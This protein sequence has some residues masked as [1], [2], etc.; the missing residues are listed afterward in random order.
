VNRVIKRSEGAKGGLGTKSRE[1]VKERREDAKE[2][3]NHPCFPSSI[4]QNFSQQDL[5]RNSLGRVQLRWPLVILRV[6]PSLL[7]SFAALSSVHRKHHIPTLAL[8]GAVAGGCMVGPN[9]KV[10]KVDVPDSFATTQPTAASLS[11][12]W[13][14]FHDPQLDILIERALAS[15]LDLQLAQDRVLEAR[16]QLDLTTGN[17]LPTANING[18]Y[19]KT[20]ISKQAGLAGFLGAGAGSGSVNPTQLTPPANSQGARTDLVRPGAA[21]A[22]SS[23]SGGL[24]LPQQ[25]QLY[26]AGFDASWEIDIFGGLR[27]SVEAAGADVQAQEESRR[28][29]MVTLLGDVARNYVQVRGIQRQ[30]HI[31]NDNIKSQQD[32]LELTRSRFKAGLATDLDVARAEAQVNTT[33]AAVPTLRISLKQSIHALGV[34]LGQPPESLLEELSTEAPIPAVPAS[35]PVGLPSD[36]LRRRPDVRRAER[37]LASST[38]RIGVATADLFPKFSLTGALGLESQELRNLPR[39][40][41]LFWDIGP[42]VSWPIFD[43]GKIQSNIRIQNERQREAVIQYRQAVLTSLEDVENAMTAYQQ[44][45][46]RRHSLAVAV[47]ANQRAVQLSTLLYTKGLA[48][49][50]NVLDAQRDLFAS[51]DQLVQSEQNVS[52]NL[53]AL[54]KALGGGWET[55]EPQKK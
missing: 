26:Q 21:G 18:G 43:A 14:Q 23:A 9:Y 8:V 15:N 28:D 40:D 29:T 3:E 49:F 44:E 17:L 12:W 52:A 4:R 5:S 45:Q 10:P 50:L 35:V 37:Q 2:D 54:Y 53:V 47:D 25:L 41:S 32:T 30:I 24:V 38:A 34:L 46:I 36:L 1:G 16:A 6:F 48:D 7:R 31:A 39:G 13:E 22:G 42:T 11:H 33:E 20:H 19:N 55:E 51:Q 27:R